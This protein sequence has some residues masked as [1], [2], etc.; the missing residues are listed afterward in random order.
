VDD[1]I[2][3]VMA[4]QNSANDDVARK[5]VEKRIMKRSAGGESRMTRRR[6]G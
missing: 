4:A 6:M 3:M 5:Q 1:V 2:G